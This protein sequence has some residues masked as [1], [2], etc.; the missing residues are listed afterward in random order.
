MY[1]ASILKDVKPM[2]IM[3]RQEEDFRNA[4]TCHIYEKMNWVQTG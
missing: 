1:I 3:P 4:V 2:V